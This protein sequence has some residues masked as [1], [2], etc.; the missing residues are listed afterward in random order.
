MN[1][2]LTRIELYMRKKIVTI[3]VINSNIVMLYVHVTF[4]LELCECGEGGIRTH[5]TV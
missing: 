3:S 1:L 4:N 2:F 5:G